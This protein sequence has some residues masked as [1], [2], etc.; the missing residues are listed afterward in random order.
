MV[1]WTW[2]LGG[3]TRYCR[4]WQQGG[5]VETEVERGKTQQ[6]GSSWTLWCRRREK[7]RERKKKREGSL[8]ESI[9]T[10]L[11]HLPRLQSVLSA[12]SCSSAH[13]PKIPMLITYL[14]CTVLV[15][16][17]LIVRAILPFVVWISAR[18]HNSLIFAMWCWRC[19]KTLSRGYVCAR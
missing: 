15:N 17:D 9:I 10:W 5:T 11:W 13:V 16:K 19:A 12:L 2:I 14:S 3:L 1:A 7:R 4:N 8:Q 6:H 18:P